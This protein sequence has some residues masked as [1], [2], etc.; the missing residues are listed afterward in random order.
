MPPKV[1]CFSSSSDHR[2]CREGRPRI[3]QCR[4][5]RGSG[6]N[7]HRQPGHQ[8]VVPQRRG[9]REGRGGPAVRGRPG[10]GPCQLP[11]GRP[12][13][14]LGAPSKHLQ[15]TTSDCY[16]PHLPDDLCWTACG[17]P[18]CVGLRPIV[19]DHKLKLEWD[20]GCWA[21]RTCERPRP[22]TLSI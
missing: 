12:R 1:S 17:V 11:G 5:W 16:R 6:R 7:P 21:P 20:D 18:H 3:P 2:Q 8:R 14:H 15:A 19:S 10:P 13:D 9:G 22:T 4:A